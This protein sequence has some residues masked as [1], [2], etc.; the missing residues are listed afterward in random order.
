MKAFKGCINPEC[1]AYK[2][3][4]YKYDDEFCLKCG[5]PLSFVCAECWKPM[6]EGK[7]RYCVSCS[8]EKE[9]K[10]AQKMAAAKKYGGQAVAFAG[11]AIVAFPQV[12]KN[13]DKLVKDAKKAVDAAKDVVKMIKK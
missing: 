13:S 6:A 4:H 2:K 1:K 10:R 3:I 8:A 11:G 12:I 5:S 7:D 9:Q